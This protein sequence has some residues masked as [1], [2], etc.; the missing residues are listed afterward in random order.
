MTHSKNL[1]DP[2]SQYQVFGQFYF[3]GD[4]KETKKYTFCTG[5][6]LKK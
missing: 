4:V 6:Y 3:L 1:N 5:T 2:S